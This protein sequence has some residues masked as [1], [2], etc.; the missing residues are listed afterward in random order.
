MNQLSST[1][2]LSQSTLWEIP[3]THGKRSQMIWRT[4][5]QQQSGYKVDLPG[6]LQIQIGLSVN[7]ILIGN[8]NQ[9]PLIV[10]KI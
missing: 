7:S 3:R 9:T 8:G 5:L 4:P 6:I 10:N 1:N 2:V